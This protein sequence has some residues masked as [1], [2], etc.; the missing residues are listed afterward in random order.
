MQRLDE[1]IVALF[2]KRVYDMAGITH[3]KV[4]VMLNGTMIDVKSF[5]DYIDLYLKSEENKELPKITQAPSDRW[6]VICSL[7]DG[8][9]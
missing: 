4:R 6:E 7:S 1:D 3:K 9:F 5:S 2:T 8:A